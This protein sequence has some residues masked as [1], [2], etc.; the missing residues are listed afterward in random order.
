MDV[1][2]VFLSNAR[3]IHTGIDAGMLQTASPGAMTMAAAV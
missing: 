3:I 1:Y 2:A